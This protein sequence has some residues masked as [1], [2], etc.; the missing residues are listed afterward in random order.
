MERKKCLSNIVKSNGR[1]GVELLLVENDDAKFLA[2]DKTSAGQELSSDE[3][4][5]EY[6]EARSADPDD[7][8][9]RGYE[10][11]IIKA[12]E[13]MRETYEAMFADERALMQK[14]I[15]SMHDQF[16]HLHKKSE[17]VVLKFAIT[18]AEKIVKRAIALDPETVLNQ[19][20]DAL[21]RIVGVEQVKIRINP[22]DA[23]L[24]RSQKSTLQTSSDSIREIILETD[25][26]I[27]RGS[28]IIE[29]ESG[30]VD[31]R[32]VSQLAKLEDILINNISIN[33]D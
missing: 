30:N 14:L 16:V 27:E 15:A 2:W 13:V 8:Y 22:D 28:C 20:K 19:I 18:V 9:R 10:E 26:K 31:A 17:Y 12:E 11:G 7:D 24:V 5:S 1:N 6:F 33:N 23:E 3:T 21:N 4:Q 32:I 25:E 29:S